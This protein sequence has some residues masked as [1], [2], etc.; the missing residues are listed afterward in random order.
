MDEVISVAFLVAYA[1][2]L[3]TSD[4][5]SLGYSVVKTAWFISFVYSKFS[6]NLLE[7]Y[8]VISK[9]L[10]KHITGPLKLE[11]YYVLFYSA[12]VLQNIII[13]HVIWFVK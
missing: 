8:P 11:M 4:F 13:T 9:L 12:E 2:P 6:I 3:E 1:L 5:E 7:F 10:D